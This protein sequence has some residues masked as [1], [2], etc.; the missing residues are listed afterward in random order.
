MPVE[1]LDTT[2]SDTIFFFDHPLS[3]RKDILTHRGQD[4]I[5][6]ISQTTFSN[7]LFEWKRYMNFDSNFTKVCSFSSN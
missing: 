6:A 2:K 1:I 3:Y 4:K 7:A 5:V